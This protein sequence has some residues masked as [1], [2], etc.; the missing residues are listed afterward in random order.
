MSDAKPMTAREVLGRRN[1][2]RMLHELMTRGYAIDVQPATPADKI[3]RRAPLL[4]LWYID[5]MQVEN[6]DPHHATPVSVPATIQV[7]IK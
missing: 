7:I 5:A 4:S 1:E 3:A 2:G 6:C